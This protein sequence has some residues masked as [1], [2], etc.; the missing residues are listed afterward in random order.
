MR[1]IWAPKGR[2]PVAPNRTRYQWVYSY[3][4]VNPSTGDSEWLILPTV[5]TAMTSLAL[6]I[7][8]KRVNPSGEKIILLLIDQAG[9]HMSAKVEKPGGVVFMPLPPHTPE[10]QPAEPAWPLLREAIANET[11]SSLDSLER[12]LVKRCRWLMANPE[13]MKG[14][15]GFGWVIDASKG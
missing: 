9:F 13:I 2:R 5:N 1:K 6:K 15:S 4:F 10:L 7:F 12:R 8:S 11:F 3:C 14:A